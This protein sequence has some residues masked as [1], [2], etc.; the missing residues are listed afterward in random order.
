MDG[1]G[2]DDM[3][4]SI[5]GDKLGLFVVLNR[6]EIGPRHISGAAQLLIGGFRCRKS[7]RLV[8]RGVSL[9]FS[10]MDC[11][12]HCCFHGTRRLWPSMARYSADHLFALFSGLPFFFS[13]F[14]S[15]ILQ[16]FHSS[17]FCLEANFLNKNTFY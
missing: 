13:S 11:Y 15:S 14:L 1:I 3:D 8:L 4:T 17:I 6:S 12:V 10:D 2:G 7:L 5:H 9:V 16:L